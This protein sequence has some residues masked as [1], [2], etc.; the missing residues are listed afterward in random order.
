MGQKKPFPKNEF[1]LTF[2]ALKI[3]YK[4]SRAFFQTNSKLS[5]KVSSKL[6]LNLQVT[7]NLKCN[8]VRNACWRF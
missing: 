6:E 7:D 1:I 2:E 8:G 3:C 4:T 5:D